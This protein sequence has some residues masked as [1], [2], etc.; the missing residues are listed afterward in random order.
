MKFGVSLFLC[1]ATVMLANDA[2]AHV[3][4]RALVL[5]LPTNIYIAFGVA[6]AAVTVF[7]T[8]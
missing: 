1:F 4:E 7:L 2:V 6:A 5:I 8:V 3:S